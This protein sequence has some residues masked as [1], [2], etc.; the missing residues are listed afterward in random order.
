MPSWIPYALVA[1][2]L[3][4]ELPSLRRARP[5]AEE[6]DRGTKRLLIGLS[7]VGYFVAFNLAGRVSAGL[8]PRWA[9]WAGVGAAVL[10]TALRVWAIRTLGRYFTRTVQVARDQPVIE[11][12]PYRLLRHP[13]YA[14]GLLAGIGVGLSLGNAGSLVAIA[15]PMLLGFVVRIRVEERALLA[16]IGEPYRAYAQRTWR[17]VPFVY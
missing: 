8:L 10:G 15:L 14:G 6:R 4:G 16:A 12:G 9:I 7:A 13:S 1:L 17:L 11:V 2:I 3:V 5:E